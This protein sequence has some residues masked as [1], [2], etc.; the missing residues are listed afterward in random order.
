[1]NDANAKVRHTS[2]FRNGL[3]LVL[4]SMA[5][6]A[7]LIALAFWAAG[8]NIS[9]LQDAKN[10]FQYSIT[11]NQAAS[12]QMAAGG[13]HC[14]AVG[15]GRDTD[16][17]QAERY[18]ELA[19]ESIK[20]L[21][22]GPYQE[23]GK[24][25]FN[26]DFKKEVEQR[27]AEIF[28]ISNE[29]D[30]NAT[31]GQHDR[32]KALKKYAIKALARAN[33]YQRGMGQQLEE[34]ATALKECSATVSRLIVFI[35]IGLILNFVAAFALFSRFSSGIVSRLTKLVENAS[36]LASRKSPPFPVEGRDEIAFLNVVFEKV[37]EELQAANQFKNSLLSM[38]A[39]DICSP[40]AAVN[41]SLSIVKNGSSDSVSEKSKELLS[42]ACMQVDSLVQY[43]R[44][45]LNIQRL[46]GDVA[47]SP[48]S[49]QAM[50]NEFQNLQELSRLNLVDLSALSQ[51]GFESLKGYRPSLVKKSLRLFFAPLLLSSAVLAFILA[52]NFQLLKI[53][54]QERVQA[55]LALDNN[56]IIKSSTLAYNYFLNYMMYGSEKTKHLAL[57]NRSREIEFTDKLESAKESVGQPV[58]DAAIL[59]LKNIQKR[60]QGQFDTM[61]AG[62]LIEGATPGLPII[63]VFV[64]IMRSIA[65]KQ[66]VLYEITACQKQIFIRTSNAELQSREWLY[67][68]AAGGII[69]TLM[70]AVFVSYA[71]ASN[72]AGRLKTV[73]TNAE[74]L[75]AHVSLQ[76]CLKGNDEIC[77][78]DSVIHQTHNALQ[79]NLQQRVLLMESVANDLR[80]PL[81]DIEKSLTSVKEQSGSLLSAI[82]SKHL[83][84]S[85]SNIERIE[86]LIDDLLIV[87]NLESGRI[88]LCP[89]KFLVF[90]ALQKASESISSL[91]AKRKVQLTIQP[92]DLEVEADFDRIV[93]VLV[94]YTTNAINHSPEQSEILLRACL[95]DGQPE[96]AACVKLSVEDNGPGLP[97]EMRDKVFERFFQTA[98][99]QTKKSG[100]GLGLAICKMIAEAHGGS[101]GVG[102]SDSGGCAFYITVA[103]QRENT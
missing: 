6:Q 83:D 64:K 18:K 79:N 40:L 13:Y 60:E 34:L 10:A 62:E 100:Y 61:K 67:T 77:F 55:N 7:A 30:Y 38:V 42:S 8:T 101:V 33:M 68:V 70:L 46:A 90:R 73:T 32:L 89:T 39:H 94:N 53:L 58:F 93:Q 45:I 17:A 47:E 103:I 51:T 75:T 50:S 19:I 56:E 4:F 88:E 11:M 23:K 65:D 2:V 92:T 95:I 28:A 98:D 80:I 76:D 71:F 48:A 41:L 86:R 54:D 44:E 20:Q 52:G 78:L 43:A 84:S 85:R 3:L 24:L 27:F 63:K 69:S 21:E 5:P 1:M 35:V 9:P 97:V 49:E 57:L 91:A 12:A 74:R 25:K 96:R 72:V 37:A 26:V 31:L 102:E 87:E 59:Q 99:S 66:A 22:S 14:L 29:S 36:F 16:R 15:L 81:C 82:C